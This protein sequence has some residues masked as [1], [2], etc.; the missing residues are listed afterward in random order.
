MGDKKIRQSR[1]Q[2]DYGI[3]RSKNGVMLA[4]VPSR[5]TP[6]LHR[7][8]EK[9]TLAIQIGILLT[10]HVIVGSVELAKFL[11]REQSSP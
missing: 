4:T 11:S 1:I 2:N 5:S 6:L 8:D 10:T 7:H 3:P 9:T